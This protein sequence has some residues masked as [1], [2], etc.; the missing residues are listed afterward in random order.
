MEKG[1]DQ[2]RSEILR[3]EAKSRDDLE[4]MAKRIADAVARASNEVS[5]EMGRNQE[6]AQQD[7][8]AAEQRVTDAVTAGS[9]AT[10]NQVKDATTKLAAT[11]RST[12]APVKWMG[13]LTLLVSIAVLVI[14]VL[15]LIND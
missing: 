6:N 7:L 10:L 3:T 2:I 4:V 5:T 9:E 14:A 13:G 12:I 15:I 8:A 11:T 1:N